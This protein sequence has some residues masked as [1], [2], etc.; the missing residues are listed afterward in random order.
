MLMNEVPTRTSTTSP[1]LVLKDTWTAEATDPF[2]AIL[3]SCSAVLDSG[4]RQPNFNVAS[5]VLSKYSTI[6]SQLSPA[7]SSIEYRS[8]AGRW[9]F[10]ESKTIPPFT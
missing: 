8:G 3:A 10:L 6:T 5:L 1:F 7:L 2:S 4:S 9:V